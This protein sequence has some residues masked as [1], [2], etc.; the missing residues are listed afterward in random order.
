M[1]DNHSREICAKYWRNLWLCTL[2][3]GRT[4]G[5]A[6]KASSKKNRILLQVAFVVAKELAPSS[7]VYLQG[8]LRNAESGQLSNMQD[9]EQ[10]TGEV[11]TIE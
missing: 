5:E 4:A 11:L 8:L 7:L 9:I 6:G 10:D 3:T 2:A 1:A